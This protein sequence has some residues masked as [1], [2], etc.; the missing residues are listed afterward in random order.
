MVE[1][2]TYGPGLLMLMAGESP[3][4]DRISAMSLEYENL[5]F[6]PAATPIAP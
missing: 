6:A 5:S 4:E 2:V 1:L 3:V